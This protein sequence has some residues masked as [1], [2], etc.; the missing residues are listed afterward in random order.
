MKAL[1]SI[2]AVFAALLFASCEKKDIPVDLPPKGK[3]EYGVVEMGE[4][5]KDQLFFDFETQ[6]VVH[7]SEINSWHL[8]FDASIEGFNVFMNGG[9]DVFV[10]NTHET[11]FTKVTTAPASF[12]PDWM[13]DRPCGLGD[14]TAIGDWRSAGNTS[15]N[16]VYIVR[17]NATYNTNNMKKFRLVSVSSAGYTIEYADLKDNVGHIITMP[18]DD[19]YNYSYFT[20]DEGGKVIQPDPPKNTWDIVFTRYRFIYYDLE[21]FTY[22]VNGVLTNP[23]NTTTAA[24]STT[25]FTEL[26]GTE[27]LK[28][29]YSNHRDIIGFNWKSFDR[30][31]EIYTVHPNKNYIIKNRAGFYWKLHFLDFYNKQGIKGSPSFEFQKVY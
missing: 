18:K 9:A 23:Y 20:F 3:A 12:S 27:I 1:L 25:A 17:L 21:N 28:L 11:D 14:S 24:D 8:A 26:E 15:K 29:P 13:F 6:R 7:I 4:D 31:K 2:Y 19:N 16:E 5:Y 30:D 10:Y 22:I